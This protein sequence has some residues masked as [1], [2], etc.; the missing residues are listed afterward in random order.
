MG[1]NAPSAALLAEARR[2][3]VSFTETI[4]IGRMGLAV[5]EAELTA[6]AQGLGLPP[7][8]GRELVRDRCADRFFSCL[9][10]AARV[11]AIDYSV[12][13]QADVIHDLNQP[14]PEELHESC[15]VCF[16]GGTMEHVFD[17]RQVLAN[18]MNLVKIGGHVFINVPANNL[19]G[20][21]FYQFSSEFFYRVFAPANGFVVRDMLVIESPFISVEVSR[22]WR[23]Y[24]TVDPA[25]VGKRVR[26]VSDRPLMIF[27]HAEK[28]ERLIP[29]TQPPLQSDYQT[30]WSREEPR[31]SEPEGIAELRNHVSR[32]FAY[33]T[34]W[35]E[36][37]R[38]LKQRRKHS[39]SNR[40]FFTPTRP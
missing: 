30:R 4:T 20:H 8:S 37:R 15:D 10:G 36:I 14:V 26:L 34:W 2:A 18:Y 40:N 39:L 28:V 21:G 11:R 32:Q 24:R 33:L 12:Y 5:P 19:F 23:C 22:D 38:R 7:D 6:I 17:V 31:P 29:F 3:G 27:V 35:Q 1:L 9:L 25:D 13:Q 16:D